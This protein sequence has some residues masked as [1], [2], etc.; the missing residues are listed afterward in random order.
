ME[1]RRP[2]GVILHVG[3]RGSAATPV[4]GAAVLYRCSSLAD[5]EIN[6]LVLVWQRFRDANCME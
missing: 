6:A 2:S 3:S 5:R 4:L 1:Q